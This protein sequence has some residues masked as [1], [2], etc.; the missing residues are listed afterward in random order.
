MFLSRSSNNFSAA[1]GR[2]PRGN[3]GGSH[4]DSFDQEESEYTGES[5][6][7][8]S[9]KREIA[10]TDDSD[11]LCRDGEE[12]API[13][14]D[15]DVDSHD[16]GERHRATL[17]SLHLLDAVPGPALGQDEAPEQTLLTLRHHTG[18][19]YQRYI[20]RPANYLGRPDLVPLCHEFKANYLQVQTSIGEW[21]S[22]QSG[23]AIMHGGLQDLFHALEGLESQLEDLKPSAGSA[24][25]SVEPTV[26]EQASR[27]LGVDSVMMRENTTARA[28]VSCL[29]RSLKD[30]RASLSGYLE[31]IATL[32]NGLQA[33]RFSQPYIADGAREFVSV[34]K[35]QKARS[36][37]QG[38]GKQ[39]LVLAND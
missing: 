13:W 17:A 5:D 21:R 3:K 18:Q 26:W 2:Y 22:T 6:V 7:D 1:K 12:R 28:A 23:T 39:G 35:V 31:V 25:D 4:V 29:V 33:M 19:I 37:T 30:W 10:H 20:T 27:F 24:G 8:S 9:D 14:V 36:E 15:S 11:A 38:Q 16:R 34:A 32:D